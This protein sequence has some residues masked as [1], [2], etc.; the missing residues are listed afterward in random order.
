MSILSR[1]Q[2]RTQ[3]DLSTTEIQLMID[4]VNQDIIS[5][6]GPHADPSN[7]ITVLVPGWRH[8]IVLPRAI[9]ITQTIAVTEIS[10]GVMGYSSIVL[11]S[12]DYRIWPPG[13]KVERLSYGTNPG[14]WPTNTWGEKIQ[15]TYVPVN[16]GDQRE[17]VIVK[18][19]V[20]GI[21][22]DAFKQSAVGDISGQTSD[23][24]TERNNLLDSLAPR[25][26]LLVL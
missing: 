25:H 7:P 5:K 4:E 8:A 11:A 19:V 18:I 24:T 23:Y 13:Y 20:I 10:E 9:D 3:T 21:Q 16:D 6:Y 15:F 12:N 26:G 17:E 14:L 2:E 22:Y 1:V